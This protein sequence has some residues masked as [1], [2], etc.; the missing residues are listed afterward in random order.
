MPS[1]A[2]TADQRG[3]PNCGAGYWPDNG[4]HSRYA[5]IINKTDPLYYPGAAEGCSDP[6]FNCDGFTG[7]VDNDGA[8]EKEENEEK[9]REEEEED[10]QSTLSLDEPC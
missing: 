5:H 7:S 10:S 9:M 6:D 2:V 3:C 4:A 8:D 1:T